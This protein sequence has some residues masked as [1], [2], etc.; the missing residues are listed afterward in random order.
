MYLMFLF[1]INLG[2]AF[3]DFFDQFAGAFLV[4]GLGQAL[5]GLGA[6]DWLQVY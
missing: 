2:G 6:P 1:T 5:T 4:D 3:I